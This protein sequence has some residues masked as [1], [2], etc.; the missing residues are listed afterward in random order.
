[1]LPVLFKIGAFEVR[2][3]GLTLA[4]SFIL[5]IMWAVKRAQKKNVDPNQ[6]MDL[7]VIII[8]CSIVGSRILYVLF[9]L[10]CPANRE[11]ADRES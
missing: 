6:V 5:G 9:H 7:S 10:A 2:S 8:I 3:Y 4:I 11:S 1:M